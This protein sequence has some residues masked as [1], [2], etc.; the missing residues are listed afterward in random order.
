LPIEG[1]EEELI[2][3]LDSYLKLLKDIE[4]NP[5]VLVALSLLGVEGFKMATPRG[6]FGLSSYP[7]DRDNLLIQEVIVD[8]LDAK[9]ADVLHPIFDTL[10]QSAGWQKSPCYDDQGN[11]VG[12]R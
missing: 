12:F 6:S 8:T 10:W 1:L 3:T 5:P 7:I 4:V 2:K 11:W 9:A